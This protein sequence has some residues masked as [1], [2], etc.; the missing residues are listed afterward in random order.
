M[1]RFR[2]SFSRGRRSRDQLTWQRSAQTL[3]TA[4]AG[5]LA[6]AN[7]GDDTLLV[8]ASA[9]TTDTRWTVRR[10]RIS[11]QYVTTTGFTAGTSYVVFIG[12]VMAE[13][14]ATA[15]DPSLTTATDTRTDWMYLG[16]GL[17]RDGEFFVHPEGNEAIC[18]IDVKA[19]RKAD[20]RTSP[21]FV[22]IVRRADTGAAPAAGVLRLTA[23]VSVLW[24]R[25]RR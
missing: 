23:Q 18:K 8:S 17:L 3:S 6:A 5:G 4:A 19:M 21:S 14:G 22:I 20:A 9:S 25:T 2:R 24:S 15:P 1:K 11:G 7:I 16:T 13:G 10:I 12:I